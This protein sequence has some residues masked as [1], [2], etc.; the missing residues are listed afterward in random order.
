M[1][2]ERADAAGHY[3]DSALRSVRLWRCLLLKQILRVGEDRC[4]R[5]RVSNLIGRVCR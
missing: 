4:V 2:P 1:Y 5:P 3:Y